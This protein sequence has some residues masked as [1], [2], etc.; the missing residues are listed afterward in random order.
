VGPGR[1]AQWGEARK[2]SSVLVNCGLARPHFFASDE[3]GARAANAARPLGQGRAIGHEAAFL[4]RLG[5]GP[6]SLRSTG[7]VTNSRW[8]DLGPGGE[9]N[10]AFR[11]PRVSAEQV[12][13]I[14]ECAE[15]DARWL[16]ADEARWRGYLGGDDLDEPAELVFYCPECAER[17]FK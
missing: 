16:P 7:R 15:C 12:A 4:G 5:R 1:C 8:S 3:S 17:E 10:G 13:L 9:P 14:P 11:L 6:Y 2:R